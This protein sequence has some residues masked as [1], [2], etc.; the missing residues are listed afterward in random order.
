VPSELLVPK[1]TWAD[2]AG[3]DNTARKLG[4]LFVENFREYADQ[5]SQAILD[6]SPRL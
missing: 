2:K 3:Y 1:N 6:A 4:K 5:A